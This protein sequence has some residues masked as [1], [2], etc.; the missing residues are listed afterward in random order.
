ME[1]GNFYYGSVGVGKTTQLVKD[2]NTYQGRTEGRGKIWLTARKIALIAQTEGI[3][4]LNNI[5][6]S[7][8]Y[9]F[10]DDLGSEPVE[11]S[12]FGTRLEFMRF[13]IANLYDKRDGKTF[14][15]TSNFEPE[16]IRVRYGD[17]ILDRLV[18]MC[19]WIHIEGESFRK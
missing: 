1:K 15:F 18:E 5:A 14:H 16:G 6:H 17:Y 4:G 3:V 9:F 10:I 11:I 13:L 7:G 12:H 8:L 2:Y 19:E